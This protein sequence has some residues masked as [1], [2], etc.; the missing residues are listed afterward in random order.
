MP[1]VALPTISSFEIDCEEFCIPKTII[2]PDVAIFFG[3]NGCGK[4][5]VLRA[6]AAA[7]SMI[8]IG[9][10]R[11]NQHLDALGSNDAP[12]QDDDVKIALPEIMERRT[13]EADDARGMFPPH[14]RNIRLGFSSGLMIH[15]TVGKSAKQRPSN[16]KWV[17]RLG[18]AEINFSIIEIRKNAPN[19]RAEWVLVMTKQD[20]RHAREARLDFAAH[21]GATESHQP[22]LFEALSEL[23]DRCIEVVFASTR[24][25]LMQVSPTV[26]TLKRYD[27]VL[28][29]KQETEGVETLAA[30]LDIISGN[31]R[32]LPTIPRVMVTAAQVGK[33]YA[34]LAIAYKGELEQRNS[35]LVSRLC[36]GA[37]QGVI[38]SSDYERAR[39]LDLRLQQMLSEVGIADLPPFLD[40]NQMYS[41]TE[42]E[43]LEPLFA[44][45][46]LP[47]LEK[48]V[49]SLEP[50]HR[51]L[52]EA[53]RMLAPRRLAVIEKQQAL[54][55]GV[56]IPED[57]QYV[58]ATR[59]ATDGDWASLKILSSGQQHLVVLLA[60]I[61]LIPI[62]A[63]ADTRAP[64]RF[65]LLD[66]P[67]IS[68]HLSWQSE[69]AR[70]FMQA[71][72]MGQSQMLIATHS[73]F[74][75]G[76]VPHRN[77]IELAGTVPRD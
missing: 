25:L 64:F 23:R 12:V 72:S 7:L 8:S 32:A 29:S 10:E 20:Y 61:W 16:T 18:S 42:R 49:R 17:A 76:D 44:E 22:T 60:S 5:S 77:S 27:G 70:Q 54:Q 66:E 31:Q 21:A 41:A 37:A 35:R 67:E 53:N 45:A 48:M 69:I 26:E 63:Q 36:R 58:L 59:S 28:F 65:L 30:F 56:E 4:T 73:N 50:L 40:P 38:R 47:S 75:S 52:G 24:R 15:A 46:A 43:R 3:H 11:L 6:I 39:S 74:L 57:Q 51:L 62:P 33:L 2:P 14:V 71:A 19:Q 1:K 68:M 34:D 55:A 13:S 9:V